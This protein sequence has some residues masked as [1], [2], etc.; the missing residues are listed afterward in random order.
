MDTNRIIINNYDLSTVSE[1]QQT[2]ISNFTVVKS[3]RG[4]ITPIRIP[5]NSAAKLKD[6]FGS[7]SKNYPELFEVECLNS[8]Y[9]VYV[10]A[11]Y[12]SATI[13]V[14]V[15]TKDG[16]F[17][18][19]NCVKYNKDVEDLV[20]GNADED[21]EIPGITTFASGTYNVLKDIRYPLTNGLGGNSDI[22]S[23]YPSYNGS[24]GAD[25]RACM[26]INTG[27]T[28]KQL[29]DRM[30]T[31]GDRNGK[32]YLKLKDLPEI[33][34][35][36][37]SANIYISNAGSDK[38]FVCQVDST[39]KLS[40]AQYVGTTRTLGD[41]DMESA[42]DN[43]IIYLY[44]TGLDTSTSNVDTGDII[45]DKY[46]RNSLGLE[47]TRAAIRTY[48]V[49]KLGADDVKATIF[50]KYPSTDA[51]IHLSFDAFNASKGY[52]NN[53]VAGRNILK[54]TVYDENAFHNANH[55]ISMTGSLDELARSESGAS[56][57]FSDSNADYAEQDLICIHT[58]SP[59]TEADLKGMNTSISQYPSIVL[60]GGTKNFETE[61]MNTVALHNLG[62]EEAK[63][64]DFGDVAYFF[65]CYRN[66]YQS[67]YGSTAEEEQGEDTKS[68]F[69][70]LAS[71]RPQSGFIYNFTIAPNEI[72]GM[73]PL[74]IGSNYWN[75]CNEAIINL[76]NGNGKITSPCTGE[77]TR[78][79]CLAEERRYG[80]AAIMY[81][82]VNGVGGQL[83]LDPLRVRYKYNKD[84]QSALDDLNFN[85]MI[86][87]H[88][89]GLMVVGNKTSKAGDISDWSFIAQT[90]SYLVFEREMKTQV[91][92]GVIGKPN[93]PYQRN[94][95]K[96]MT[97]SLVR[98]RIEG[99][100]RI[101]SQAAVICD[102]SDGCN[103]LY[104]RRNRKFVINVLIKSEIYTET[105]VLNFVTYDQSVDISTITDQV[106]S[107]GTTE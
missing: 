97:E 75:L 95:R 92:L 16:I 19:E 84:Q 59:F 52:P 18:L 28:K 69:F 96:Q 33:V 71:W 40:G 83:N 30:K 58:I 9:D 72:S 15:V 7:S 66:T 105:V 89:Y 27:L 41:V 44:I 77:R 34:D 20:T 35:G 22:A 94:L 23:S 106:V 46:V 8:Y 10:S 51:I 87:D 90:A 63:D 13:P 104:A 70:D 67:I 47:A 6:I 103:D 50:P 42:G 5:A 45:T 25:Q 37:N 99:T 56:L 57:G 1:E 65:D 21:I 102:T 62:W 73:E 68:V 82:N 36:I 100:N 64:D 4:M 48:W 88:T 79:Q 101:W 80:G 49:Q 29:S 2:T 107:T 85:P 39:G 81:T 26:M 31:Y 3:P 86:L 17:P 76:P 53:T 74:G 38:G 93:N 11:P 24:Y 12:S 55:S 54:L 78:M 43:D 91:L 60:K 32:I 98:K 61:E 14:A